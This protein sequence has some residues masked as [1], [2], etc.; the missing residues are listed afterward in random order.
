MYEVR[1]PSNSG[2][3]IIAT[4]YIAKVWKPSEYIEP[5]LIYV[6][7]YL[8]YMVN[9]L[10]NIT[11]FTNFFY[12]RHK[13]NGQYTR[14]D[15]SNKTNVCLRNEEKRLKFEE[16]HKFVH[17]RNCVCLCSTDHVI[18]LLKNEYITNRIVNAAIN[19]TTDAAIHTVIRYFLYISLYI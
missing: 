11:L 5:L 9:T 13:T 4:I 18:H 10:I 7:R 1:K 14:T 15:G 8:L 6:N 12:I 19:L 2:N 16:Q 3:I 17:H